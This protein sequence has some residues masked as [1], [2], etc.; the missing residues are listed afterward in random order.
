MVNKFFKILLV[1][2]KNIKK[3]RGGVFLF[4]V[5]EICK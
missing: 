1:I 5:Y 2:Y 4:L 3:K